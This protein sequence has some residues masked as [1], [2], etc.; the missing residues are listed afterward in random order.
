MGLE[1]WNGGLLSR[2]SGIAKAGLDYHG[3]EALRLQ[4]R[5]TGGKAMLNDR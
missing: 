1:I 3:C 4:G 2:L 5:L